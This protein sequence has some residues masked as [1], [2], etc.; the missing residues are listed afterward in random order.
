[1]NNVRTDIKNHKGYVYIPDLRSY[2]GTEVKRIENIVDSE[3][4][5]PLSIV[6]E[7]TQPSR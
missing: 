6:S 2:K 5:N 4:L 3:I 1:V 7:L